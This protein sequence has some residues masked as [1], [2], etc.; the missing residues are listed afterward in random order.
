MIIVPYQTKGNAMKKNSLSTFF[1]FA[2]FPLWCFSKTRIIKS[3]LNA[4]ERQI[5]ESSQLLNDVFSLMC[6]SEK[7][8][9][10][11]SPEQIK[12]GAEE[13]CQVLVHQDPHTSFLNQSECKMLTE[14]MSG[15]FCGIG[16]VL[17][18]DKEPEEEFVP[19]I[20]TV[21]GGPAEK[22]GLKGGD[23][24]VQ[25]NDEVIKGMKVD[26]AMA[27]LRG[28]KG[29]C[30]TVKIMRPNHADLLDITITRDIIKDE[31]PLT[32]YFEQHDVYYLLLSIFSEKSHEQVKHLLQKAYQ[33]QSRGVIIDLRNNTGGLFDAATAIAGLFLPHNSLV[34]TT[35][36]ENGKIIDSWK[37]KTKP[38]TR[39]DHFP[40]FFIVNN[41]TASSAEI[42]AGTLRIYAEKLDGKNN[43]NVFIVGSET[44]GKGSI[45]EVI[46]I[47]GD[48]ALKLTTALYFLPFETNVQGV[49][50]IPD[51][52]IEPLIPLPETMKW[53]QNQFGRE[54]TLKRYIK[55]KTEQEETKIQQPS[56]TKE[57]SWKE[58]REELL[59]EDYVV[60]NTLNLIQLLYI[61][62][63]AYPTM[64]KFKKPLNIWPNHN[65]Y[66]IFRKKW[67]A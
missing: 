25:I 13:A 63:K 17:P 1:L 39:P 21:P 19:I 56:P 9:T 58:K 42:L 27:K 49:G 34:T 41:Y 66:P 12:K 24:V 7:Y 26:E 53:M 15:E 50:I 46:P 51:F 18:G 2:F 29:S 36:N 23:K 8:Y 64:K 38:L 5:V 52:P 6:S 57:P 20:E 11:L 28:E 40:I 4:E 10:K 47:N 35:K 16:V 32:Y 54:K 55:P 31:V 33:K 14:R 48:C 45:Q 22:A 30:V 60:Q 59:A 3:T 61:G 37:T 67:F 43:L 65:G 62:K 44:F